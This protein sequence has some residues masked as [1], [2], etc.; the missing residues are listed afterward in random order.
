MYEE[1]DNPKKKSEKLAGESDNDANANSAGSFGLPSA[2]TSLLVDIHEE[3]KSM[4]S[5]VKDELQSFQ[6]ELRDDVSKI[7]K[8]EYKVV[9]HIR[10]LYKCG[11]I[12]V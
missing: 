8:L 5:D 3:I 11:K 7:I 12:G 6:A 1:V 2:E 10:Q 9:K 4:R